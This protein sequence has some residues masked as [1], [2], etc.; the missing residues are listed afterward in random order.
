MA[1]EVK[2]IVKD[3]LEDLKAAEADLVTAKELIKVGE[4]AGVDVAEEKATA[5]D[6]ERDMVRFKKVL[7]KRLKSAC[8]KKKCSRSQLVREILEMHLNT[9]RPARRKKVAKKS[10]AQELVALWN[11]FDGL[12]KVMVLSEARLRR[13]KVRLKEHPDLEFWKKV[14]EK[15]ATTPFLLGDNS[16]QWRATFDWII[17]NDTN[18]LKV[19]EGAYEKRKRVEI[20]DA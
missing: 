3:I 10:K 9:S 11:S 19:L 20:I 1:E 4:E 18:A 15:I 6:L 13:L 17:R 16:N 14:F 8:K 5:R 12:P 7:E 2:E